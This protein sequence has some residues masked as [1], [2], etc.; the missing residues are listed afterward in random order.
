MQKLK[1]I[2][3]LVNVAQGGAK[4]ALF[5][6]IATLGS[7]VKRVNENTFKYGSHPAVEGGAVDLGR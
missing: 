7:S 5:N 2:A 6:R 1:D 4:H 3:V